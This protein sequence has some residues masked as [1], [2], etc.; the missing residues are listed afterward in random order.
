MKRLLA[1]SLFYL[2][3][4]AGRT[5]VFYEDF[6]TCTTSGVTSSGT[7]NIGGV[8]WSTTCPGSTGSLDYFKCNGSKLECLDTNGE[9]EWTTGAIDISS[10]I[11]SELSFT[12]EET[13]DME[14]C[15]DCGGTGAD[16]VDYVYAQYNLDGAGW[17]DFPTGT[18]C[19]LGLTLGTELV[20]IGDIAGGGPTSWTSPC[21]DYGLELEIKIVVSTWAGD[22]KYKIDDV[23]V[24]CNDCVLSS[25]LIDFKVEAVGKT[26]NLSWS[27]LTETNNDHFTIERSFNGKDYHKIGK[28]DG[29]GTSHMRIDYQFEDLKAGQ[30]PVVYYRLQQID[31]NGKKQLTKVKSVEFPQTQIFFSGSSL[32]FNLPSALP[33]NY[34]VNIYDIG[35]KLVDSFNGLGSTEHQ[36][37]R[38]GFYLIEIPELGEQHKIIC[39]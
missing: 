26:A 9:A 35:G 5:Q 1:I 16:C 2:S 12:I 19:A 31:T 6:S 4:F 7:D 14:N 22:E 30:A 25:E 38:T 20:V 32:H 24:T 13:G 11:G 39:Q 29:A 33:Q 27:T 8:A 17:T 3:A 15:A 21:I 18:T 10:C 34:T 36:W 23:T 37:N 28:I